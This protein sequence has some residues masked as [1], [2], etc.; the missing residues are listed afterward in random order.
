[1]KNLLGS[2]YEDASHALPDVLKQLPG[3]HVHLYGKSVRPGRKLGHVTVRADDVR[4]ARDKAVKAI[5]I[6]FGK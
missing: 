3:V 1:M 6:L 5:D 4:T 2:K